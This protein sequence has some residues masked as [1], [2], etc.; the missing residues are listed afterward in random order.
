MIFLV[1][2]LYILDFK[3][4]TTKNLKLSTKIIYEWKPICKICII[5]RILSISMDLYPYVKS[6][7]HTKLS[8]DSNSYIKSTLHMNFYLRFA[9]SILQMDLI[10]M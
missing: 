6:V 2:K 4:I 1:L 3:E 7:L 10:R 9:S 5:Y 8:T